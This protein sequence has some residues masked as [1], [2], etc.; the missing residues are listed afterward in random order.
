MFPATGYEM[1]PRLPWSEG[2][3]AA[4]ERGS[5]SEGGCVES[6]AGRPLASEGGGAAIE[7]GVVTWLELPREWFG[8]RL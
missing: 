2:G 6:D 3:W 4:I 7:S 5:D 8:A 1:T